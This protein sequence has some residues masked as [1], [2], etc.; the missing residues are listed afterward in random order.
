MRPT[1]IRDFEMKRFFLILLA[2][3]GLEIIA[4]AQDIIVTKKSERIDAKVLEININDVKYKDW[5]NQDGPTYTILKSDIASIIYQNGKVETFSN[6]TQRP[7]QSNNNQLMDYGDPSMTLSQFK[8][9]SDDEQDKYFEKYG[10]NIYE[11]FHS[12]MK[13]RNA[14]DGLL[15][16][17]IILSSAGFFCTLLGSIYMY[18]YDYYDYHFNYSAAATYLSGIIL[19]PIGQALVIASIPFSAV[20][21]AKKRHAQNEY[22]NKYFNNMSMNKPVLNLGLTTT[23]VGFTLKF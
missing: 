4:D 23:G 10:G 12:G 14:G 19:L 1:R 18:H 17:G 9:M 5:N 6:F 11:T 8:S 22:I 21:G 15:V 13:L 7:Q 16:P 20:G 3:I 2:V